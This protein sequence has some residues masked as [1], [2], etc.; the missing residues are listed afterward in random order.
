MLTRSYGDVYARYQ[1]DGVATAIE[2][3]YRD[4]EYARSL[5]KRTSVDDDSE[6]VIITKPHTGRVRVHQKKLSLSTAGSGYDS[7]GSA[8][9]SEDWSVVS[10][11]DEPRQ[12]EEQRGSLDRTQAHKRSTSIAAAML[13]VLPD[14]LSPSRHRSVSPSPHSLTM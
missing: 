3:I 9:A 1:E 11:P 7:S 4:L 12:V 8:M 2:S 14:S 6:K 13:S 10:D 5:I